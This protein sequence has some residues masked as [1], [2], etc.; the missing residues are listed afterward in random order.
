R[1][2]HI[3]P[4]TPGPSPPVTSVVQAALLRGRG[5]KRDRFA[6]VV[7]RAASPILPLPRNRCTDPIALRCGGEG[8]GEGVGNGVLNRA[9]LPSGWSTRPDGW[10][11]SNVQTLEVQ[12]S[13][14]NV[15]P[16]L[17]PS[18]SPPVTSV[19]QAALLRGRGGHDDRCAM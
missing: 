19:V 6:I 3:C 8:R 13:M 15:P 14:F 17:T 16:P 11:T 7:R 9:S 1:R 12:C 4:L 10:R 2:T 5:G 18:P